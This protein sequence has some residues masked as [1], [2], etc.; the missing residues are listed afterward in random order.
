MCWVTAGPHGQR[1]VCRARGI[2]LV[3]GTGQAGLPVRP[4]ARPL[5]CTRG[6][7]GGSKGFEKVE[8]L[9]QVV[10]GEGGQRRGDHLPRTFGV[11]GPLVGD[12][13]SSPTA[14]GRMAR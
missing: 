1:R 11:P 2:G 4:W 8:P 5:R 3:Q 9:V 6:E 12:V 10:G 7:T 13:K 14:R